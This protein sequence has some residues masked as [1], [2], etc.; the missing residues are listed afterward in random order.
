M[1]LNGTVTMVTKGSECDVGIHADKPKHWAI[2]M[3]KLWLKGKWKKKK[4]CAF[5]FGFW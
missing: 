2:A 4:K 3:L 5:A 1:S